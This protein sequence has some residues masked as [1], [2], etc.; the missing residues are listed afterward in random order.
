M[1]GVPSLLQTVVADLR[2]LE[3][4]WNGDSIDETILRQESGIL[5]RLLVDGTLRRL[6]KQVNHREPQIEAVDLMALI[7]GVDRRL[8]AFAS[9]GGGTYNNMTVEGTYIYRAAMTPE[10]IKQRYERSNPTRFIGLGKYLDNPC[11]LIE[12]TSI[13]RSQLIQYFANK[14][15]GVHFDERRNPAKEKA[16]IM[17]D[18]F[19]G[20][21]SIA[22]TD[23]IHFE[24]LSMGQALLKSP[25]IQEL[26]KL[27]SP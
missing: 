1:T 18:S 9:A 17:L 10:Q 22:D 19:L 13:K 23:A 25:Q 6:I 5:R 8:V 4:S 27:A 7:G 11:L 20:K 3:S 14:L 26:L 12:G 21:A 16:F 15:G 2:R 24:L